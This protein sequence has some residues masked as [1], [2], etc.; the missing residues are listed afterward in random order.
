MQKVLHSKGQ[1]P[2][3]DPAMYDEVYSGDVDCRTLENVFFKFN[4]NH[5]PFHRGRSLSVSDV[6]EVIKAPELVGRIKFFDSSGQSRE[7]DHIDS[8]K[9]NKDISDALEARKEIKA[10][11]LAGHNI[12]SVMPGFYFCDS[13]G[14]E[15]INFDSAKTKK[16]TEILPEEELTQSGGMS[17]V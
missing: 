15:H 13:A 6:I 2:L 10:V 12:P 8:E 4:V 17:M 5:P 7:I 16:H 1:S 3:I 11:R 9:Y 14:Y